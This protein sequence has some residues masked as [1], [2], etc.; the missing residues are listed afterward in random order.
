MVMTSSML[1]GCQPSSGSSPTV[2]PTVTAGETPLRSSASPPTTAAVPE[3]AR[4]DGVEVLVDGVRLSAGHILTVDLGPLVLGDT[5][6]YR[7][8]NLR[9]DDRADDGLTWDATDDGPPGALEPGW[10]AFSV[11][12]D[13]YVQ[14]AEKL[15]DAT[16]VSLAGSGDY[17]SQS[18]PAFDLLRLDWA[19]AIDEQ[20]A[21]C[22]LRIVFQPG[23]VVLADTSLIG[24]FQEGGL[25]ADR[26]ALDPILAAGEF[27]IE[28]RSSCEWA[29][30]LEYYGHD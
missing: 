3:F 4:Y 16:A 11:G 23:E 15:S 22:D 6:W 17:V 27:R 5:V 24:A 2:S 20:L 8:H 21:P 12:A 28:I 25:I 18:L 19:Q 1:F 7:V 13:R 10:I 29:V 30:V 26:S 14:L 9:P